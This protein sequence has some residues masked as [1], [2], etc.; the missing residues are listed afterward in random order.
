MSYKISHRIETICKHLG[1]KYKSKYFEKSNFH[2]DA[3]RL[4]DLY[5]ITKQIIG[6]MIEIANK[7]GAEDLS[8]MLWNDI[9]LL[10]NVDH[11]IIKIAK[12]MDKRGK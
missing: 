12:I 6:E 7:H 3:L 5:D 11:D 4:L 1:I 8:T 2:V 10:E 9:N